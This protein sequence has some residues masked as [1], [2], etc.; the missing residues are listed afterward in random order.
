MKKLDLRPPFDVL[1]RNCDPFEAVE[2]LDGEEFRRVKTRRT[3]RFEAGGTGFF[4]KVHHGTTW[5]EIFKNLFQ[6]KPPVL[7]AGNEYRAL[8][9]LNSVGVDTMTVAAFGE[10]G[11]NPAARRSFLVTCELTGTVSLEDFVREN[12]SPLERLR[13]LRSLAFSAG[14]MHRAG[15]N[16]RD[17][18]LCH[19][20][21]E[22]ETLASRYP[23]L[24]V[25]DLHR[26]Q[27]RDAVPFRYRVKDVAGLLFSAFDASPSRRELLR[28]IRIYSGVSLRRTLRRDRRFWKAV[29]FAAQR[30]Y[31]KEFDRPAP[32]CPL[33]A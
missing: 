13:V 12:P 22:R 16:H 29:L 1:W 24:S 20:L 26:A 27:L 28:F 19:Y 21:L 11:W 32:R 2:A 25:I 9:R 3:F 7:G 23:T 31:R 15:V 14:A 10:R 33:G 8:E 5:G 30:L 18:Y 6:L 4:A 17:C